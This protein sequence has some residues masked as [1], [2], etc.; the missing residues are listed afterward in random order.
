LANNLFQTIYISSE[1]EL[2]SVL[3][4]IA[5][6]KV[7]RIFLIIPKKALLFQS[8]INLRILK[9]EADKNEIQLTIV[10]SDQAGQLL[11]KRIDIDC[12]ET[13]LRNKNNTESSAKRK[14]QIWMS[15]KDKPL[16]RGREENNETS[17]EGKSHLKKNI[18]FFASISGILSVLFF[19]FTFLPSAN[20]FISA[21]ANTF[22]KNIEF[23][24]SARTSDFNEQ[25]KEIPG[26]IIESSKEIF[27][28][29]SAT[30]ERAIEKYS[31][32]EIEISNEW[33]SSSQTFV[34]GTTVVSESGKLFSIT[35]TVV[36]PGFIRSG[37]ADVIGK[38]KVAI[39]AKKPG[40]EFNI[41]QQ[42]F[43]IKNFEGTNKYEK[44]SAKSLRAL[45]GGEI[46][47]ET[48]VTQADIDKADK[49]MALMLENEL[50]KNFNN[51]LPSNE[52]LVEKSMKSQ[53]LNL[54]F[55]VKAGD[56]AKQFNV[57]ATLIKKFWVVNKEILEKVAKDIIIAET[58]F[59]DF[60]ID[61]QEVKIEFLDNIKD[62][63]CKIKANI[64]GKIL[65]SVS[66]GEIEGKILGKDEFEAKKILSSLSSVKEISIKFWP[67]WAKKIP[68]NEDKVNVFLDRNNYFSI[69]N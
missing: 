3:E 34:K 48:I 25:A 5:R 44:I 29:F 40:A 7:P 1:E 60:E 63:V 69:I 58:G 21:N 61:S 6:N 52:L 49:V 55:N 36:V 23:Y 37:G 68:K 9:E 32:G 42:K 54:K 14:P 53:I 64:E 38:A 27:Q 46:G 51:E 20:V 43:F 15:K 19:I 66:L 26:K 45:S 56:A 50:S 24:A 65:K 57:K 28:E 16:S 2:S 41:S 67:F 17:A 13:L 62:D 47:S 33:D 39:I 4:K 18:L 30:G 22:Q 31:Q 35:K 10:T 59:N 11:A 12:C 8:P